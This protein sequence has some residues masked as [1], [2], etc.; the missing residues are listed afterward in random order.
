[1]ETTPDAPFVMNATLKS[2]IQTE[3]LVLAKKPTIGLHS[4]RCSLFTDLNIAILSRHL[5]LCFLDGSTLREGDAELMVAIS[6]LTVAALRFYE[7][8]TDAL[9][10]ADYVTDFPD[11]VQRCNYLLVQKAS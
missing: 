8:R 5:S 9:S 6:E 2:A 3:L 11:I 1:M 4:E 7:N 10:V